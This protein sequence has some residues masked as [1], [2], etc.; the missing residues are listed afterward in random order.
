M[1]AGADFCQARLC[2]ARFGDAKMFS[3][4]L[5]EA[6]LQGAREINSEQLSRRERRLGPP[7]PAAVKASTSA[8]RATSVRGD[9]PGG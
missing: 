1:L 2:S 8:D 3:A 4:D 7:C 6:N 9:N 5:R